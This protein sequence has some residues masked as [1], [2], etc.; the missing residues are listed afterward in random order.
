MTQRSQQSTFSVFMP[1]L[2]RQ[3][4]RSHKLLICRALAMPEP[5]MGWH[6]NC[7][8]YYAMRYIPPM[9]QAFWFI[10]LAIVDDLK[11]PN[12]GDE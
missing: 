4:M 7:S 3:L 6:G 9:I 12:R 8:L 2:S 11:N 10:I 5:M 1:A